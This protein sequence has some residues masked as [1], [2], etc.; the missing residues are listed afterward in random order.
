MDPLR[1][2][3]LGQDQPYGPLQGDFRYTVRT[4]YTALVGPNNAGKSSL[5]QLIFR[6]LINDAEFGDSRICLVPADRAYVD[7]TTQTGGR[8]LSAWNNELHGYLSM[9]PLSMAGATGPTRAELTRLLLHGDFLP[10]MA[11]LNA[12]L[13]RFGLPEVTLA[14]PQEVQF[15]QIVVYAQGSGLRSLLPVLAAVTN[16]SL[17]VVLIDEPELGL[18]PRLQKALRDLLV[19]TAAKKRAVIVATHSHLLVNRQ[20]IESTQV[21]T[22]T[23]DQTVVETLGTPEQ[24]FGVTFDLL[25]SSTED[26]FFPKNYLIVEGASDQVIAQRVLDLLGESAAAIKVLAAQGIDEVREREISVVRALVPLVVNDSPYAGRVVALIDAPADPTAANIE[27]LRQDLGDRLYR[28][29]APSVEA[30]IPADIYERAGRSKEGDLAA[31]HSLAGNPGARREMKRAISDAVA[32]VLT[33]ADLDAIPTIT[34]S[35]RRAAEI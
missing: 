5:L 14:G 11:K 7:A 6:F 35:C 24:L 8:T 25:G 20:L 22:R 31:L 21:V 30:Y 18:E 16:D 4:E 32:A 26:L 9:S 17:D 3:Q 1:D 23:D 13:P 33:E 2:I 19:E 34:E 15:G 27:R 12:L 10:Q 28:L 29:D